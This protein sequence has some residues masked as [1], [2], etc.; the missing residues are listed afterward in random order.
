MGPEEGIAGRVALVT[1]AAGRGIGRAVARRLASAGAVVV[2][3]D[4]HERRTAQVAQELAAEF[5]AAT[6]VGH[7]LD[8]GDLAAIDEVVGE[9]TASLGPVR[10]LV[11]NAA[12]NWAGPVFGYDLDH[13]H[14]TLAVNLTGPWYLCRQTMPAMAEAGGGAIVNMSSGAADEGGGFGTEGVYAITKGALE[15]MTRALAHDGGPFGIRVNT[16]SMGI[17]TGTK[18]IDDHPDQAERALPG[19]PLGVHP[20]ADDVAEA[21]AFL[22]SDRARRITGDIL[23]V[24]GGY[25]MRK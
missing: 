13:W 24:N 1:A 19:V 11:N 7:P 20:T 2:V 25:F 5:P 15:T 21:V 23:T 12:V 10:I 4:S 22:V 6:V 14:A 8:V 3:T 18:F 16:V 17:V 9:V